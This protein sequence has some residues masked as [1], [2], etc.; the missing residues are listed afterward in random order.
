MDNDDFS[1]P[2]VPRIK[3]FSDEEMMQII[4]SEDF[5]IEE[6]DPP[7][8]VIRRFS[9]KI[10]DRIVL[11]WGCPELS[12]YLNSI[13]L[14]DREGRGGFPSEVME[15]LMQISQTTKD[16]QSDASPW[17]GRPDLEKTFKKSNQE[18]ER[19]RMG[20]RISATDAAILDMNY[21]KRSQSN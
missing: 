2:M 11:F 5:K 9:E 10:A 15:A 3:I 13:T 1:A 21:F 19:S 12:I 4:P 16:S 6:K 7:I 8:L 18:I 20:S 14:M 17:A